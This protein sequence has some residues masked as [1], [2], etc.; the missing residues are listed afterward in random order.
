MLLRG[1]RCIE[2]DVWDGEPRSPSSSDT[3]TKPKSE[4][5]KHRFMPHMP[6]SLSPHALKRSQAQ[7]TFG[8]PPPANSTDDGS[9][10]LPTPWKSATTTSRAEPRV[11]HGYTL[12]K[13]VAFRDVCMAVRDAAFVNR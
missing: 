1:C 8:P 7:E 4:K 2:I 5:K 10:N 13:E 3:E 11:L 9:L 6:R 12:T